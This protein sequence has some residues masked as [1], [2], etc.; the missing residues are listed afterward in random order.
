M[1]KNTIGKYKAVK[2]ENGQYAVKIKIGN[3]WFTAADT[4]MIPG[5]GDALDMATEIAD[6]LNAETARQAAK[7][8]YRVKLLP[9]HSANKDQIVDGYLGNS[10]GNGEIEIYDLYWA[11]RKARQFGGKYERITETK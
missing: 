10:F 11:K 1:A 3:R 6:L 2:Q 4:F 7:A 9:G 8:K 5:V